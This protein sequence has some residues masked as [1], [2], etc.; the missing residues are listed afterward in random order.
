MSYLRNEDEMV[1][2]EHDRAYAVLRELVSERAHWDPHCC[3][4]NHPKTYWL[5]HAG[6]PHMVSWLSLLSICSWLVDQ[7]GL[8]TT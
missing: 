1:K 3:V 6:G 4:T 2:R 7:L 8:A 5:Q